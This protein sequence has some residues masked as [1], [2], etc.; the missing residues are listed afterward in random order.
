LAEVDVLFKIDADMV[1]FSLFVHC[2][3]IAGQRG[4]I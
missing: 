3:S 2:V 4:S 1:S